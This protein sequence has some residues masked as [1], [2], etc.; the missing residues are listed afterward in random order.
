MTCLIPS[1]R[2]ERIA[3]TIQFFPHKIDFP[4]LTRNDHLLNVLDKITKALRKYNNI[5]QVNTS[6][7]QALEL[8]TTLLCRSTPVPAVTPVAKVSSS[9]GPSS[10]LTSSPDVSPVPRVEVAKEIPSVPPRTPAELPRVGPLPP[11][12]SD[13]PPRS[14]LTASQLHYHRQLSFTPAA[15]KCLPR[16]SK[17]HLI[18]SLNHIYTTRIQSAS[19]EF[20]CLMNGN[21]SGVLGMQA[22]EMVH[23]S[24]ISQDKAITYAFMVVIIVLSRKKLIGVVWL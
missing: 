3:N 17:I 20:G 6:T 21:R 18:K 19:N 15:L 16:H 8:I 11:A 14:A 2:S 4:A 23:P 13:S 10:A 12:S 22:M 7:H 9:F 5:I 1:T 24:T